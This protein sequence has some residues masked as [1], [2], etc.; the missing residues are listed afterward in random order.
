MVLGTYIFKYLNILLT[1]TLIMKIN[2]DSD[3][4]ELL[5]HNNSI[6]LGKKN[7]QTKSNP[8]KIGL[9]VLLTVIIVISLCLFIWIIKTPEPPAYLINE[10]DQEEVKNV[11]NTV[12]SINKATSLTNNVKQNVN[13]MLNTILMY[14]N[15]H[16]SIANGYVEYSPPDKPL[17]GMLQ[18]ALTAASEEKIKTINSLKTSDE[19]LE[20][21]LIT[22]SNN[23]IS[24]ILRPSIQG[25]VDKAV[26]NIFMNN[27]DPPVSLALN[28]EFLKAIAIAD[29]T[30][31]YLAYVGTKRS[32]NSLLDDAFIQ[33]LV[34][35][36]VPVFYDMMVY[37][38]ITTNREIPEDIKEAII[39]R[40]CDSWHNITPLSIID[41]CNQDLTPIP[42][43]NTRTGS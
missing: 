21:K 38:Y 39:I 28:L 19:T 12:E 6:N 5:S 34:A 33:Q 18:R 25:Y 43:E 9:M 15:G 24:K 40:M 42:N 10:I 35:Q 4:Q 8:K 1:L 16:T 11:L 17:M 31:Y 7:K 32:E 26:L 29:F 37:P 27:G 22:S 36:I 20:S 3:I 2:P 23:P 14:D 41:K 13:G 30:T